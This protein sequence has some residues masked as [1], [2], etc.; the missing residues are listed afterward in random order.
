MTGKK[1]LLSMQL[2]P[3]WQALTDHF[4]LYLLFWFGVT[5]SIC[6]QIGLSVKVVLIIISEKDV[7]PL[8]A[9][10]SGNGMSHRL[11]FETRTNH[12][13]IVSGEDM[14]IGESRV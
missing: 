7:A 11:F 13:P 8:E 1:L 12:F 5:H 2:K 10:A 3:N 14:T 4:N 6:N 9:F